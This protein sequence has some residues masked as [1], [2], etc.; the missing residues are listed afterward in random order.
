MIAAS[1]PSTAAFETYPLGFLSIGEYLERHGYHVSICNL[2]LL[3]SFVPRLRPEAILRRMQARMVG[4]D[5]HWAAHTDGLLELAVYV[6]VRIAVILSFGA[7]P[8][9]RRTFEGELE[10]AVLRIG[11]VDIAIALPNIAPVAKVEHA[12]VLD[13]VRR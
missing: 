3:N 8:F 13:K 10:R 12:L 7:Y 5:L 4:I 6:H 2:A 11:Y 1:V 9:H